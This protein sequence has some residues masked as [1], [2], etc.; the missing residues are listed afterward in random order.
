MV[1]TRTN[2]HFR[3]ALQRLADV[4]EYILFQVA[5]YNFFIIK[6]REGAI[7]RTVVA[8]S[9]TPAHF[10]CSFCNIPASLSERLPSPGF[11][12]PGKQE[13]GTMPSLNP[14]QKGRLNSFFRSNRV[15]LDRPQKQ[16]RLPFSP[17]SI[18]AGGKSFQLATFY[19][20]LI[21]HPRASYTMKG[22]LAKAPGFDTVPSFVPA[23]NGWCF[24]PLLIDPPLT[25]FLLRSRFVGYSSAH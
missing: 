9:K 15:K 19:A 21:I 7:V 22:A 3:V 18:T 17:A 2:G 8:P 4:G 20:M 11:S 25:T 10:S 1:G 14:Y 16:E 13:R 24:T 5:G 23:D 6:D 12:Y